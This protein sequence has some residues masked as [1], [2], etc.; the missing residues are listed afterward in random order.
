MI[1]HGTNFKFEYLGEFE[2]EIKNILGLE[3]R[4]L[5]GLI[6]EKKQR[7]KISCYCTFK[8]SF[9]KS[10]FASLL[11]AEINQIRK[12]TYDLMGHKV[13]SSENIVLSLFISFFSLH[14]PPPLSGLGLCALCNGII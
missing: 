10:N 11:L 7:R 4:A 6:H 1:P 5:M 8:L 13:I 9:N 12:I 3:S 2:M 14:T